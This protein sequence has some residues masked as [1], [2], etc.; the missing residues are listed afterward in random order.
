MKYASFKRG[1][2]YWLGAIE[3]ARGKAVDPEAWMTLAAALV[4][5]ALTGCVASIAPPPQPTPATLAGAEA[6]LAAIPGTPWDAWEAGDYA[7]RASC[8]AYL[9]ELAGQA[10]SLALASSGL[11][12]GA[13]AAGGFLISGGN[14]GGAAAATG[15]AAL[16]QSFL[17]A[18]QTSR[19]IPY[20]AETAALIEKT[21]DAYEAGV[22]ASPPATIAQAASYVDDQWWNCSYGGY[23]VHAAAAIGSATIAANPPVPAAGNFAALL[24]PRPARP[25]IT[26]NGR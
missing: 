7:V 10:S 6:S 5:A 13:A 8:H 17:A 3:E 14:P 4:A 21:L 26:V 23:A 20:T 25:V 16:A 22:A 24:M 18:F 11:G 2:N 9:G 19:A 15:L 12:L 1:E